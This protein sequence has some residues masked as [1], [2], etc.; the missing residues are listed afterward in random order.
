M[1]CDDFTISLRTAIKHMASDKSPEV[2]AF[3]QQIIIGQKPLLPHN[4]ASKI[5]IV[6]NSLTVKSQSQLPTD[7]RIN[8]ISIGSC[9]CTKVSHVE[10][11][12]LIMNHGRWGDSD[13]KQISDSK[14][15]KHI[16]GKEI[17]KTQ[18]VQKDGKVGIIVFQDIMFARDLD[19][20]IG[21]LMTVN[22]PRII[23]QDIKSQ[24][25][26]VWILIEPIEAKKAK[27][28]GEYIIKGVEKT[29]GRDFHCDLIPKYTH[30]KGA[31]FKDN[32]EIKIPLGSNSKILVD[33]EFV[34]AFESMNIG[35]LNITEY[36]AKIE[37]YEAI[38]A[39]GRMVANG[40][41]DDT[42][43]KLLMEEHFSL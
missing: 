24:T 17:Q 8:N 41:K 20:I 23:E 18:I 30:P 16:S 32:N 29:S 19:K 7:T 22:C 27:K 37:A 42:E 6:N 10:F 1:K 4:Q 38:V 31:K 43:L 12:N 35:I 28:F 15:K 3:D 11:I 34:N 26:S 14:V 36:V 39:E 2:K 9:D 21:Y 33:N 25:Y 13:F 40:V 5:G